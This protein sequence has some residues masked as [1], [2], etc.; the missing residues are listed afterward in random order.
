MVPHVDVHGGSDD[1]RR[2]G[3]QIKRGQKIAGDALREFGEH[4]G[5]GGSDQQRV[6]RLGDGDVLDGGIDI[7]RARSLARRT[8]R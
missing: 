6:N 4:I 3:R 5:G 2:G 8:C 1:D 7:R